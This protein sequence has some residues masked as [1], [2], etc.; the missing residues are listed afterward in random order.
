MDIA[1]TVEICTDIPGIA[2]QQWDIFVL[3]GALAVADKTLKMVH[4]A[5]GYKGK[6]SIVMVGA[7]VA[8]YATVTEAMEAVEAAEVADAFFS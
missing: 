8:K 7:A 3:V 6:D 1:G 2:Q 4:K 5:V